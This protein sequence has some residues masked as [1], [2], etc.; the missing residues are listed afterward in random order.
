MAAPQVQQLCK[1]HG[2]VLTGGVAT[3]KSTVA[4]LLRSAG[5]IVIDADD[6][7][8]KAVALGKPGLHQLEQRFGSD[9]LLPDGTL[10]RSRLRRLM[11]NNPRIKKELEEV[12]HPAIGAELAEAVRIAGLLIQPRRWFY[13]ASLI[14]ETGRAGQFGAVW[15]TLC[16]ADVQR[17]R[18]KARSGLPEAEVD[19][20]IAAQLPAS[21]K[22]RRAD[23][24][25]DTDCTLEILTQEVQKLLAINSRRPSH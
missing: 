25:I 5:E 6:L 9:I 8:R 12:M 13:E 11:I 14:Y 22:A 10:D 17:R 15:C 3:G 1:N 24:V 21:E 16:P 20:I 4:T 19:Q 2:I 7:A 23:V 18:L